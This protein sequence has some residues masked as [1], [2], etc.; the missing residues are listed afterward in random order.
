MAP[1]L[2]VRP[3]EAVALTVKSGSPKVLLANPPNVIVWLDLAT[4]KDWST[5]VAGLKL[6]S[7]A[8]VA[9]TVTVPTPVMVTV[10]PLMVTGPER[11]WKLTG[12]PDDAV[13]LTVKG[14]SPKVLFVNAPKVI[15]WF[16]FCAV[17]DSVT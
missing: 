3:E 8:C 16:A 17:T 14:A 4:V 11:I 1:K 13:A 2:T 10:L 7:P 6:V 15:V 12:K 5:G 9:L